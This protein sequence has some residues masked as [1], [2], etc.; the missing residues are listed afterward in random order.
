M[1]SKNKTEKKSVFPRFFQFIYLSASN[2]KKNNLWESASAC[3]F[4][5]I[6][7]FI[8]I[9]LIIITILVTVLRVSPNVLNYV[10]AFSD[11]IKSV[12][13][14]TPVINNV[15]KVNSIKFMDI[16]LAI[17]VIWMA[18]KMFLSIVR[19]MER[20]FGFVSTRKSMISQLLTF[21]SEFAL[22]L[23]F[24]GVILS[25]FI[26]NQILSLPIFG[27]IIDSFPKIIRPRSNILVVSVL[28][29]MLFLYVL[30]VYKIISG[31]N[32]KFRICV[33]YAALNTAAFYIFSFFINKFMNIT[34]Y[35]VIYGTISTLVILMMK[36]YFF[37]LIFLF[38]AQMVYIS[39][40]F[41]NILISEIYLLPSQ[42]KTMT[43]KFLEKI[44]FFNP[45]V[46]KLDFT[47]KNFSAGD[48]IYSK[49]ET[50]QRVFYLKKGSVTEALDDKTLHYSAGTFFGEISCLINQPQNGTA[51][52]TSDCEIL[53]IPADNFKELVL[54]NPFVSAYAVD[55]LNKIAQQP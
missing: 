12:V 39:Q 47:T 30:Y 17:W 38:C 11:E 37:F 53:V 6:F 4:G 50:A 14:I 7:S 54:K 51:I 18:R 8:P 40:F 31:T 5:F 35:N 29:S 45:T 2:F 9:T 16:F 43:V 3:S 21:I 49:N 1:N 24:I 33:F 36:V 44:N 28:Y 48:I 15:L 42:K 22:V 20:I 34:N 27:F 13:D 46:I 41:D 10:L 19:A 52:A 23:I 26:L 25:T 55:K 32:P